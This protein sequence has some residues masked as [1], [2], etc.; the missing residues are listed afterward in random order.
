MIF[1]THGIK[2]E[3]ESD[4]LEGERGLSYTEKRER[5]KD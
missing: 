3:G 2:G 4:P 1:L 5:V